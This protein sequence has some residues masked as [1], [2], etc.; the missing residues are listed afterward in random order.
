M[1]ILRRAIDFSDYAG[2]DKGATTI[3]NQYTRWRDARKGWESQRA[4]LREYVYQTDTT[5]TRAAKLPWMNTTTRPKLCQIRDNLHANYISALSLGGNFLHWEAGVEDDA[6]ESK[7]RLMTAY[8]KTKMEDSNAF[9]TISQLLYDYIDFGISIAGVEYVNLYN[10]DAKGE[11]TVIY[12][13][14]RIVRYNPMDVVFDLT[15]SSFDAAP[16]ITRS[17]VTLGDLKRIERDYPEYQYDSAIITKM[18]E[19]RQN[20]HAL[21]DKEQ[22]RIKSFAIE[23]FGSLSE[24]YNSGCVELLTFEGDFYDQETGVLTENAV[25]VV[26]DRAHVIS[27][28]TNPSWLGKSNKRGVV[29]RPRPDNLLGMGPL[30]NLVGLQ[31][32]IDHLENLKA[33]AFDQVVYP[34]VKEKGLV[35]DWE[36]APG[37][38]IKMGNE[39]EVSY[40]IPDTTFL[41]ADTQIAI[42]ENTMEEMAGAPKTA[43]GIRTPGEKTAY[44]VQSLE[45]AAG[46]I[47]QVKITQFERGLIEP[48]INLLLESGRRNM[49]NRTIVRDTSDATGAQIYTDINKD[50][51][52]ATGR[53]RPVGARHFA[54]R[55]K[56]V[57]EMSAFFGPGG[58][59]ADPGVRSHFSGKAIGK[60]FNRLLN[61]DYYSLYAENIQVTESLETDS[62]KM[63]AQNQLQK[64]QMTDTGLDGEAQGLTD[65]L[66]AEQLAG[67]GID[68]AMLASMGGAPQ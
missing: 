13:G 25:I 1:V 29:W 11:K 12:S 56:L 46:R 21:T 51:I 45:N 41:N 18:L 67:A 9:D 16:K 4:E 50:D 62:M 38:R 17:V 60:L 14:P 37:E 66:A 28:R 5:M 31:Y 34:I 27:T 53:L 10:V 68:P 20:F 49:D 15:A 42:L 6:E 64:T 55:A 8:V 23:G 48:V 30:D 43:M 63:E 39:G 58:L 44:E 7:A 61:L 59:G 24:Y 36:Y 22:A 52:V 65:E 33:D 40:L 35:Q 54:E 26:A 2:G 3:V 47:F 57:Q 32:R 19:N